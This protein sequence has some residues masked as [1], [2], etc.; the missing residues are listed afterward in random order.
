MQPLLSVIVP[1]YNAES[2][3]PQ[4][5]DSI[6]KQNFNEWEILL[7]DDGS[8]DRTS[9]LCDSYSERDNRIRSFHQPNGG[10]SRARNFGIENAIGKW[11]T[12]LDS[13]DWFTKDAF[14]IFRES[15]TKVRSDV[16]MFNNLQIKGSNVHKNRHFASNMLVREGE[17]IMP[18][19][20]D[21]LFPYYDEYYNGISTG[22]IRAVHGKLYSKSLIDKN[23]LKF[24]EELSIAED[25]LFN[26]KAFQLA[27]SIALFDSYV[28]CYRINDSSVMHK[29]NPN[30]DNVN[31][32]ILDSFAMAMG[33]KL[34][35]EENFKIAYQGMVAEC[36]FRSLKLKYLNPQNIEPYCNKKIQF[37]NFLNS[38]Q[39]KRVMGYNKL[40]T[41]PM[42]KKQMMWCFKHNWVDVG[43]LIGKL[44]ISYLKYKGNI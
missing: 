10:V 36:I 35:S 21:T 1:C 23:N 2:Y 4:A 3:L 17:G 29:Y 13:D 37:K 42:G 31:N 25:A 24:D 26:Y 14:D 18:F 39:I 9:A 33:E 6:V 40:Y 22:N 34:D 11:I 32:K 28:M 38:K 43:M 16:Y 30:I 44:S 20:L 8:T 19:V 12:F 5:V 7:V 27:H 15:I 41:L